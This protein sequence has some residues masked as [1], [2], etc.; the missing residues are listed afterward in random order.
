MNQWYVHHHILISK[1]FYSIKK[2]PCLEYIL[3]DFFCR[4]YIQENMFYSKKKKSEELFSV[5]GWM[6]IYLDGA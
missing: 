1:I 6:G 3:C 2:A 5:M 4:F